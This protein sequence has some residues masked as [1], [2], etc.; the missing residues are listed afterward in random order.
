MKRLAYLPVYQAFPGAVSALSAIKRKWSCA[1]LAVIR[2]P[3]I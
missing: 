3:I 2:C 1:G